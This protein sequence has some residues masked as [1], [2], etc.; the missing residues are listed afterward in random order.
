M[1]I[2]RCRPHGGLA[3]CVLL[4]SLSCRAE[5][6]SA[7]VC[8]SPAWGRG[9][10]EGGLNR[11]PPA[12]GAAAAVEGRLRDAPP[13]G[14]GVCLAG[15][16]GP[17]PCCHRRRDLSPVAYPLAAAGCLVPPAASCLTLGSQADLTRA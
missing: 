4:P 7:G 9:M 17:T 14:E 15:E 6:R 13:R 5:R 3:R 10:E 2:W 11:Y 1:D 8:P 16:T 12:W